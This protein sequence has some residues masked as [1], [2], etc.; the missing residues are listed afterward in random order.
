MKDDLLETQNFNAFD[1]L[2]VTYTEKLIYKRYRQLIII[3]N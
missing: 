1:K 3:E 2:R